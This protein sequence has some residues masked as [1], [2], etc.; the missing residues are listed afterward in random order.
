VLGCRLNFRNL[1]LCV[2]L[3][4]EFQEFEVMCWVCRLNF[5]NLRLCV[6]LQVEY[7]EFEGMCWVAG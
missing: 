1:R 3:Q 5:R 7:Q 6:G 4:V 2:G